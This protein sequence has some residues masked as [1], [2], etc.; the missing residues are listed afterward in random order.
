MN[1][2]TEI[3]YQ[4]SETNYF[5]AKYDIRYIKIIVFSNVVFFT[6]PTK[7]CEK[8][9]FQYGKICLYTKTLYLV[10]YASIN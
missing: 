7:G 4:I 2:Q 8:C 3:G 1:R 5:F 9:D 6:V 10:K